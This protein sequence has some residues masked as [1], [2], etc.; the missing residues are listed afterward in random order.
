MLHGVPFVPKVSVVTVLSSNRPSRGSGRAPWRN[1]RVGQAPHHSLASRP[2]VRTVQALVVWPPLMMRWTDQ[3]TC[4]L[5]A[6]ASGVSHPFGT[7]F[8]E[9][10]SRVFCHLCCLRYS[11][12]TCERLDPLFRLHTPGTKRNWCLKRSSEM[13]ESMSTVVAVRTSMLAWLILGNLS[14]LRTNI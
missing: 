14:A 3:T 10:N 11:I 6:G 5:L 8:R 7:S 12:C 2:W 1:S 9:C 13:E 4:S